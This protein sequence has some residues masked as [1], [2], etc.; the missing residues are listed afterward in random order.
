MSN[1]LFSTSSNRDLARSISEKAGLKF[2]DCDVGK[3]CDQEVKVLLKNEVEDEKVFVVGGSFPPADNLLEL[4]ILTH[5]CKCNG[6]KE[7]NVIVPYFGY[8]KADKI[9]P[10][11]SCMSAK[12]MVSA[13]KE[14][15]ADKVVTLNIH[16]KTVEGFFDVPVK[17]LNAMPELA[18]FFREKD[19]EKVAVVA[20]DLG[21][22]EGADMFAREMGIE[23]VVYMK[24]MRPE[25]DEVLVMDVAGNVEGKDVI[26]VDDMIQSGGT[27]LKS[28]DA[29]KERGA[30]DV[31]VAVV[32][33]LFSGP[34]VPKLA[35][36]ENIKEVVFTNAIIPSYDLPEKFTMIPVD[37]LFVNEIV[38]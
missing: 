8:A 17:D 27:I 7:V 38:C 33:L 9:K 35:E 24:K 36:N 30:K 23:D 25:F 29:L 10:R 16:S 4:F 1:Y 26:I 21:G 6:A 12:F 34:S 37:D 3:F 19:L 5:T 31:Y 14:A 2:G 22:V 18:R 15:G 13:L 20:P 28:A 32:H 11:G